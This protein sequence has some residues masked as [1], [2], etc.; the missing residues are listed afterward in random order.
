MI[1]DMRRLGERVLADLIRID[2]RI[3]IMKKIKDAR[4]GIRPGAGRKAKD[5]ATQLVLISARVTQAQRARFKELGGSV[6]LRAKIDADS[7]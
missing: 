6:W 1:I 2:A 4:G 7:Q 3:G 5:G